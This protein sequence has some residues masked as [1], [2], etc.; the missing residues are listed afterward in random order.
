MTDLRDRKMTTFKPRAR[1]HASEIATPPPP[2]TTTSVTT[3]K[4]AFATKAEIW[5]VSPTKLTA[6]GAPPRSQQHMVSDEKS[7]QLFDIFCNEAKVEHGPRTTITQNHF[8]ETTC[9]TYQEHRR[10]KHV[11]IVVT[12]WIKL[13]T[14][15]LPTCV[16]IRRCTRQEQGKYT[17]S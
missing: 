16:R 5:Q 12:V 17:C 8:N 2:S 9:D 10:M 14:R 7:Q 4:T 1:E 13:I 6:V 11:H 3:D 15:L